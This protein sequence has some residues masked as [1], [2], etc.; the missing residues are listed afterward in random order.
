MDFLSPHQNLNKTCI[1]SGE[2]F[3]LPASPPLTHLSTMSS[4][5]PLAQA[6]VSEGGVVADPPDTGANRGVHWVQADPPGLL[7]VHHLAP[8]PP[9]P[10]H[11]N[12]LQL[13]SDQ[14]AEWCGNIGPEKAHT[15][16]LLGQSLAATNNSYLCTH[17]LG[18]VTTCINMWF[19]WR[20]TNWKCKAFINIKRV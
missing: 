3:I 13:W 4:R 12:R 8:W 19:W 20:C 5:A 2:S 7:P 17:R 16:Y 10:H 11:H 18:L 9:A 15:K 6:G 14:P 1:Q